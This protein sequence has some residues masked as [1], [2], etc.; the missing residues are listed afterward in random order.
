MVHI[1]LRWFWSITIGVLIAP[2]WFLIG[3]F[4]VAIYVT[5]DAG[6]WFFK[7]LSFVFSL[8][9]YEEVPYEYPKAITSII[10]FYLLGW[11]IG[12]CM[13]LLGWMLAITI[14]FYKP[15]T[16]MVHR[17]DLGVIASP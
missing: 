13:I 9:N 1:I 15:G 14:V 8:E 3:Y 2:L 10:W 6:F 7:T 12:P 17:V 11:F 16:K 4:L 5:R